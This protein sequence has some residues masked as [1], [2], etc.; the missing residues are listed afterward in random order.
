[1]PL[2]SCPTDTHPILR[3]LRTLCWGLCFFGCIPKAPALPWSYLAATFVGGLGGR[4][5]MGSGAMAQSGFGER[6]ECRGR[7]LGEGMESTKINWLS[8]N[9]VS[10]RKWS[11]DGMDT[12][13]DS[14]SQWRLREE[15]MQCEIFSSS[16]CHFFFSPHHSLPSHI[17]FFS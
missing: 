1:M 3:R 9:V 6:L 10:Q 8:H 5:G 2:E 11:L 15:G 14:D 12:Q 16:L 4:Y 17:F 13:M 7:V